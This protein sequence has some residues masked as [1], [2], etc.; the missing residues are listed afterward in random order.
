[1]VIISQKRT[2]GGTAD[3]TTHGVCHLLKLYNLTLNIYCRVSYTKGHNLYRKT[4]PSGPLIYAQ[5]NFGTKERIFYSAVSLMY[6]QSKKVT[7]PTGFRSATAPYY[8]KSEV[9]K[10]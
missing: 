7:D 3:I 1:M 8:C 10:N 4:H 9:F 2:R 6:L 5:K